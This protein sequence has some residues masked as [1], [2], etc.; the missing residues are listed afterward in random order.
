[1]TPSTSRESTRGMNLRRSFSHG[2]VGIA[3]SA[4]DACLAC[5]ACLSGP[6]RP[7]RQQ[8]GTDGQPRMEVMSRITTSHAQ[9]IPEDSLQVKDSNVRQC[10]S[11]LVRRQRR[12]VR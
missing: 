3:R 4:R 8:Q 9:L 12:M 2:S 7:G 5:Q 1:M 6:G 10:E 11:S